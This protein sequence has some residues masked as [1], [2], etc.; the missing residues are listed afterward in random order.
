MSQIQT[1]LPGCLKNEFP[2]LDTSKEHPE[3]MQGHLD[4]W[5]CS[6]KS[7]I[8]Q[9][10]AKFPSLDASMFSHRMPQKGI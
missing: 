3:N 1:F 9:F 10:K 2:S 7:E 8:L 5:Q 4:Q 6:L